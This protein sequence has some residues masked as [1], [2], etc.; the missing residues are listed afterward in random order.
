[1]AVAGDRLLLG[2]GLMKVGEPEFLARRSEDWAGLGVVGGSWQLLPKI[3]LKAQLDFH[4]RFY[5]SALDELGKES[6]Q[7]SIGGWWALDDRRTLSFSINE[8]LIV[9]TAPDVSLHLSF[10]WRL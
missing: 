3:G 1:M 4:S 6:I 5:D 8:D 7:I 9:R 2:L 10:S